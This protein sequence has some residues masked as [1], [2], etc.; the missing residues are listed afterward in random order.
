M[1]QAQPIVTVS[2]WN[3]FWSLHLV[4]A[5]SRAGWGVDYHNTKKQL[6]ACKK[7]IRNYP[8]ALFN[9]LGAEGILSESFAYS[10]SRKLVD[11]KSGKLA[12][13]S[14]AFW[15]WS[16]CSLSG[17][18][19]ARA[20]HKPAI[21]ERGSSHCVWQRERIAEEY[22]RLHL[23]IN[24]LSTPTE[25]QYDLAEYEAADTICIPSRFV[26]DTFLQKGIAPEKLFV[27]PY[28]VDFAFW[29]AGPANRNA[30][31]P[32][33]FLWVAAL[34][35]R[36]GIAVLLEAW[37][38]AGIHDARLVLVGPISRS[39][40][41]MLRQLPAGVEIKPAMDSL[42]VRLEMSRAH[43]YVLPSFE[44]GMA[45]S[46]LE[47][48]AAGLA[49]LITYETG[50]TDILVPEQDAWVLPAGDSE[51]WAEALRSAANSPGECLRKGRAAQKSVR[52]FS[53]EAYGERAALLLKMFSQ[54]KHPSKSRPIV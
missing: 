6:T 40:R 54:K 15:G 10:I 14:Q 36:K 35:P 1:D 43:A 45:R 28:G 22:A 3:D 46:V 50:A 25:I 4:A 44:E 9:R 39:V 47:A 27:N 20:A 16:G 13:Q 21:L 42:G 41:P 34:M 7:Y 29:S 33:T 38:K 19:A 2:V 12:K 51:V 11:H 53:W 8:A 24:E 37:R 26:R 17:L 32:F 48:A 30:G 49:P 18:K 5:L 52:P 23:P 31:G